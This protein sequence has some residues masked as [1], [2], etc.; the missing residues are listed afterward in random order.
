MRASIYYDAARRHL[1]A[2]FEGEEFDP[3][4]GVPHLG[5]ALACIAI[6]VDSDAAGKLTDDRMVMGGYRDF[7]GKLAGHVPRL[8][9][10]HKDKKPYKHY[11]RG[12][13]PQL[14]ITDEGEFAIAKQQDTK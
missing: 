1:A 3:D 2:W 13:S 8:K 4:D 11:I 12:D 10:L 14:A 7:M 9:E 6:L 5:A